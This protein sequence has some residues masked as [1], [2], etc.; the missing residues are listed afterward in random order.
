MRKGENCGSRIFWLFVVV[1]DFLLLL[2]CVIFPLPFLGREK[3][4]YFRKKQSR[5]CINFVRWDIR[6]IVV[7]ATH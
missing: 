6:P 3:G 4:L 2:P 1:F 5:E 7:D